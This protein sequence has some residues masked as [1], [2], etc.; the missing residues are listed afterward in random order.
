MTTRT[1][2]FIHHIASFQVCLSLYLK[3]SP[4]Y[5]F[6]EWE[7]A[8]HVLSSIFEKRFAILFLVVVMFHQCR[9]CKEELFECQS[10]FLACF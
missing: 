2:K 5:V 3:R 1:F 10:S 9:A 6:Y 8:V 4:I 7:T